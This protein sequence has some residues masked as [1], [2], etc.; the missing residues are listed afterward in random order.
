MFTLSQI[1]VCALVALIA[2]VALLVVTRREVGPRALL[3]AAVV[4][5]SVL[6]WRTAANTAALNDDPIPWVSPNDVLCPVVTYV[7]L[8][9]Y[10]GV[11]RREEAAWPSTR[12]LLTLVS[13]VVNVVTI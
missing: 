1:V 4:A 9:V 10:A 6:L 8:G 7:T 12:A 2:S 5:G 3:T 11:V 13:L